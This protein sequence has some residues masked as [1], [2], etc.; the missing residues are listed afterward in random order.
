MADL[1]QIEFQKQI[2]YLYLQARISRLEFGVQMYGKNS[3]ERKE[4][5]EQLAPLY[6]EL[7]DMWRR[8]NNIN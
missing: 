1:R 8:R 2:P 3:P 5:I 7:M 6:A 4:I